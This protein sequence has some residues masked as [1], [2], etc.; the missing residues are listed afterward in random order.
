MCMMKRFED[1]KEEG[2]LEGLK[3]LKRSEGEVTL[4]YKEAGMNPSEIS[5]SET[6][7]IFSF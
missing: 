6:S 4:K 1:I 5:L 7:R 3:L 2:F